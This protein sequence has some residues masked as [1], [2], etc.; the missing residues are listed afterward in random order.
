MKVM[1]ASSALLVSALLAGMSPQAAADFA[2][3][4]DETNVNRFVPFDNAWT[5]LVAEP[6]VTTSNITHCIATGSADAL[7][8]KRPH[9]RGVGFF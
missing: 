8:P 7:N 4:G 3:G 6:F 2:V 5:V 9:R 1:H